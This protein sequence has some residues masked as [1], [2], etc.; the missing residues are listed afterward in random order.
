MITKKGCP[1]KQNF[2]TKFKSTPREY[3]LFKGLEKPSTRQRNTCL[4]KLHKNLAA[5][6]RTMK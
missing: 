3:L 4:A 1:I 5:I 2:V 6:V